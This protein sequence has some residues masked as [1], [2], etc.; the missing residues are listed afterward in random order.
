[1]KLK[2]GINEAIW[3]GVGSLVLLAILGVAAYLHTGEDAETKARRLLLVNQIRS[4]LE[5]AAEAE[6]SAVLAI[7]DEDSEKFAKEA[8][9]DLALDGEQS[10]QLDALLLPDERGLLTNYTRAF[11]ELKKIDEEVLALAVK[12]TN[13]KAFSLAFGPATAAIKEL[14]AALAGTTAVPATEVRVGAW[15]LLAIL[16]LHIAEHSDAK[17][18]ALESEMTALDQQVRRSLNELAVPAATASYAKFSELRAEIIKLSR[19]NTN[20][21]SLSLSLNE[22]RQALATCEAALAALQSAVEHE[23]VPSKPVGRAIY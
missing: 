22:K 14:D 23:P 19:E 17:M 13:L 18:D 20:V 9:A 10:R 6:K 1:M 2:P 7:T 8:R 21:R 4:S 5:S 11:A 3:M 12:N 15:R 16:P